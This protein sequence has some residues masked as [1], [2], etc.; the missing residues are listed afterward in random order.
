VEAVAAA[1]QLQ[2][3]QASQRVELSPLASSVGAAAAASESIASVECRL[4]SK[5]KSGAIEVLQWHYANQKDPARERS[6]NGGT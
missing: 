3:L 4:Q 2:D 5:M 6:L 1:V